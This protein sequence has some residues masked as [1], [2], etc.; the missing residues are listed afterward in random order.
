[1]VLEDVVRLRETLGE[2]SLGIREAGKQIGGPID[3]L[4]QTRVGGQVLVQDGRARLEGFEGIED[5]GQLLILYVD[6]MDGLLRGVRVLRGNDGD[7]LAD[8]P[9][10]VPRQYGH[11]PQAHAHEGGGDVGGGDD[12]AD[13]RQPRGAGC[14]DAHDAGVGQRA[15][16]SLGPEGAGD[17]QVSR[18]QGLSRYLGRPFDAGDWLADVGIG[19]HQYP[20]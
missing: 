7:L 15:S 19:R 11:V 10:A 5:R 14:V 18:V 2:V 9:D 1:M 16:R 6:K 17:A 12:G 3:G 13:A 20:H 4:R 8:E